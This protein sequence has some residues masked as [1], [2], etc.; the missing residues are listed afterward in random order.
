LIAGQD[1]AHRT[2]VLLKNVN[3]AGIKPA[4][5]HV[6]FADIVVADSDIPFDKLGKDLQTRLVSLA[7]SNLNS[8]DQC[9]FV[10]M[11]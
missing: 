10:P 2:E 8:L 4:Q 3:I 11:R 6:R 1:E 5:V 9:K 7:G